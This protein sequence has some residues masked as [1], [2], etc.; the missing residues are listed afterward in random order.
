M[1]IVQ[2]FNFFDF[3]FI[4]FTSAQDNHVFGQD[5]S[6]NNSGEYSIS[7]INGVK[8]TQSNQTS[9]SKRY[10]PVFPVLRE[11]V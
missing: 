9:K 11:N 2:L 5:S 8:I 4:R 1:V 10:R 7:I 3:S 6:L